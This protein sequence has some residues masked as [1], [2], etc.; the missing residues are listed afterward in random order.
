M[1]ELKQSIQG[2]YFKKETQKEKKIIQTA[3]KDLEITPGIPFINWIS[4]KIKREISKPGKYVPI[5]PNTPLFKKIRND[6]K[7][8]K[9]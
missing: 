2:K 6:I 4:Q 3:Q 5:T 7:N 1:Q 8:A 9:K